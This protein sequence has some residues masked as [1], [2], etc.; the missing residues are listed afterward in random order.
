MT[1]LLLV[2]CAALPAGE[3]GHEVLDRA[4]ADLGVD[5]RWVLWDDPALDWGSALVAVRSTWDYEHRREDFLAWARSVP[6]LLN[7]ADAFVWNTDKVYLTAMAAAGL[8]VVP[9]VAVDGE[10]ELPAAIAELWDEFGGAAVVKPRVGAGGRG[11][12]AFDGNDGGPPGLDE[13]ELG[14]GPWIVQPLVSSVRTEGETSVFVLGG[15]VVSGVR[16]LPAGEEI[17][18]Q[19]EF[20]G[21]TEPVAVSLES[22]ELAL[23]ALGAAEHILGTRLPYARVDQL[24]LADGRLALSELELTEPGLYLEDLPENGPAF[25]RVVAGM[26]AG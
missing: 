3:P 22:S 26:L 6:R 14:P 12:V 24:R 23:A 7:G 16:K 10:E 11:V 5:A 13:S 19:E 2:T 1:D 8:P 15:Q 17:R 21:R 20:G 9:T 25:A 4:L 18:V